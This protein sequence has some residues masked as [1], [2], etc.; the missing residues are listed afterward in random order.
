MPSHFPF[1]NLS[2]A[3]LTLQLNYIGGVGAFVCLG[4]NGSNQATLVTASSYDYFPIIGLSL[5]NIANGDFATLVSS[6][7]VTN[8]SWSFS[9]GKVALANDGTITQTFAGLGLLQVV[10]Y[11]IGPTQ[12]V[13]SPQGYPLIRETA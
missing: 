9:P 4:N 10:G 13:F 7:I 1:V 12:I 5:A 6:G 11:A 3:Y 8:G 2:T